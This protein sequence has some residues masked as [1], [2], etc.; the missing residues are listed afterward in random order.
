[1]LFHLKEASEKESHNYLNEI[2]EDHDCICLETRVTS[3][4]RFA[5]NNS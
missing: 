5:A 3:D 1:M 2:R 4:I